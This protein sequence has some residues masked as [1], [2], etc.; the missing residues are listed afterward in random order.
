MNASDIALRP[1]FVPRQTSPP[2]V[3]SLGARFPTHALVARLGVSKNILCDPLIHT[4]CFDLRIKSVSASIII[5]GPFILIAP[6]FSAV[7]VT[8]P[9]FP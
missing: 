6:L 8:S 5:D 4:L 7:I 1:I 2:T 3:T 9:F